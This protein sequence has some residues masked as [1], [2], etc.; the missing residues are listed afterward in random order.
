MSNKISF[1]K[2]NIYKY[3]I[4]FF[5]NDNKVKALNIMLPKASVFLK[6]YD[7]QTK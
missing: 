3:F 5:Y 2:K 6:S 7:G 1:G 4:R